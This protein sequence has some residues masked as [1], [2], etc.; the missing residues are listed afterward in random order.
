M[1]QGQA[2]NGCGVPW[3]GVIEGVCYILHCYAVN[4]SF[5]GLAVLCSLPERLTGCSDSCCVPKAAQAIDRDR[6]VIS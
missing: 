1:G 2:E 6:G 5:L 4:L 3:D